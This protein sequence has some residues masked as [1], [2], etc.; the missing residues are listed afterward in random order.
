MTIVLKNKEK[1]VRLSADIIDS[2]SHGALILYL[3]IDII[4]LK[5]KE[6]HV[7]LSA[8]IIDSISHGALILYL[9]KAWCEEWHLYQNENNISALTSG[10][11]VVKQLN[12]YEAEFQNVSKEKKT[13]NKYSFQ[14]ILKE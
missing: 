2:I 8:D 7:R 12:I 6:K 3:T 13:W 11:G 1:H 10:F 5:N 14:L 4:V 9:T